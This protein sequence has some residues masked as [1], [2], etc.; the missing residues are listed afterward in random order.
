MF[1][2]TSFLFLP[3]QGEAGTEKGKLLSGTNVCDGLFQEDVVRETEKRE[4]QSV[5]Q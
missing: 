1:S 5:F 4:H 3:H 2:D